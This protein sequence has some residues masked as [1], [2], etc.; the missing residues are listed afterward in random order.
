MSVS[1]LPHFSLAL[2]AIQ[3]EEDL[4]YFIK[5][6]GFWQ[7]ELQFVVQKL[8]YLKIGFQIIFF[9][10]KKTNASPFRNVSKSKDL[11][12]I[13]TLDTLI[14]GRLSKIALGEAF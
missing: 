6:K 10:M 4:P 1:S 3:S 14:S 8:E 5:C 13:L 2:R 9:Y 11:E 7:L 12:D